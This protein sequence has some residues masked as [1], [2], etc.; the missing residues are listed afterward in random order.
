MS[1]KRLKLELE[2]RYGIYAE[3]DGP[4]KDTFII[5]AIDDD[6]FH[7]YVFFRGPADSPYENGV[8][9]LD[10]AIPSDYPFKPPRCKMLT[11]IHHLNIGRQG[12]VHLA[13]LKDQWAP[14]LSIRH[15]AWLVYKLLETPN[16]EDALRPEDVEQYKNDRQ[17]Y[18]LTAKECVRNHALQEL[19]EQ[20]WPSMF[21]NVVVT[22]QPRASPDGGYDVDCIGMGGDVL[23]HVHAAAGQSLGAFRQDVARAIGLGPFQLQLAL[24]SGEL[25]TYTTL[26]PDITCLLRESP[27]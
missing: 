8:F 24:P 22:L 7:W 12:S 3:L 14:S 5:R 4:L 26:K 6:P 21:S 2:A 20:Q 23:A 1:L 9:T 25:L 16:V 13:A 18:D 19:P 15:I 10:F 17:G 11:K 27:S